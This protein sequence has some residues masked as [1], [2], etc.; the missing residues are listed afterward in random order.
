MYIPSQEKVLKNVSPIV[1]NMSI[2]IYLKKRDVDHVMDTPNMDF[3]EY[4]LE[5]YQARIWVTTRLHT[6]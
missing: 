3:S 2:T 5:Y 4:L 1:R 6:Y